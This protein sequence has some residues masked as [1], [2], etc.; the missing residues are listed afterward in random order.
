MST[1]DASPWIASHW[2]LAVPICPIVNSEEICAGWLEGPD[3]SAS[4]LSDDIREVFLRTARGLLLDADRAEEIG[5]HARARLEDRGLA[6]EDLSRLALGLITTRRAISDEL[7][8]AGFPSWEIRRARLL[9]DPRLLGRIVGPIC[10][11][12]GPIVSFWAWQPDDL[13]PRHLFLNRHWRRWAPLVGLE[14]ALAAAAGERHGLVVVEEP[15]DAMLLWARGMPNVAAIAGRGSELSPRC[16][17]RLA[18]LGVRRVTLVLNDDQA[19]RAHLDAA[20]DNHRR[21]PEAPELFFVLPERL[22]P[23]ATPGDLV[24]S[25]GVESFRAILEHA[26]G[27]A[28]AS[29]DEAEESPPPPVAEAVG[30]GDCELHR[31][32]ETDCFCFD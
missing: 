30:R 7:R 19:A 20:R 6:K 22:A 5:R 27:L 28:E 11:P 12:A 25:W 1:V 9:S 14:T 21:V 3:R 13:S 26:W 29:P 4:G 17:R 18:A 24:R 23:W 15:L 10:E 2:A 8:L 16:W 32:G 31:C